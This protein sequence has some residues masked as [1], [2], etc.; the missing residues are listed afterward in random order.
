MNDEHEQ[1]EEFPADVPAWIRPLLERAAAQRENEDKLREKGGRWAADAIHRRLAGLGIEPLSPAEW[2]PGGLRKAVLLHPWQL[3][4]DEF[5]VRVGWHGEHIALYAYD[6]DTQTEH[7]VGP[8]NG[9]ED[10]ANA[11]RG[12]APA[13]PAAVDHADLAARHLVDAGRASGDYLDTYQSSSLS[14]T[15]AVA[16]ALLALNDTISRLGLRQALRQAAALGAIPLDEV[17][18]TP[19]EKRLLCDLLAERAEA[20][21]GSHAAEPSDVRG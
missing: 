4:A 7:Y 2:T 6:S 3:D 8:L 15:C 10:A 20:T 17:A 1:P 13:Q 9:I 19:E 21:A 18:L 12:P 11:R 5:G 16:E 14:A